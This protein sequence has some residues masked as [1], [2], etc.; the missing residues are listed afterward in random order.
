MSGAIVQFAKTADPNGRGLPKW[1]RYGSGESYL[2]YN[3]STIQ[4]TKL[5]SRY[6]DALDGV[7]S[8]RRAGESCAD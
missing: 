3:D 8:A 1:T 6:L 4:K 2:E 5:R 7:F